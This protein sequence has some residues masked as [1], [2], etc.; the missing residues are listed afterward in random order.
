MAAPATK[1]LKM[2]FMSPKSKMIPEKQFDPPAPPPVVKI[3]HLSNEL[4]A[5]IV[6]FLQDDVRTLKSCSLTSH[7][8][9]SFSRRK[10]FNTVHLNLRNC[11][12]FTK[13]LETSPG[14]GPAVREL[15]VTV[16]AHE[17]PPWVDNRLF[18]ISEKLPNVAA[19][20]LKGKAIFTAA[21]ILGFRALRSIHFLGCELDS[22]RTFFT[23]IGSFPGMETMYAN[24]MVVYR[25]S[26]ALM[27][28]FSLP[29]DRRAKKFKSMSFNSCRMDADRFA[30]FFVESGYNKTLDYFATCPL[31]E[32]AL[33]AVG[34]ILKACGPRLKHYKFALVGMEEQG[35]YVEPLKRH[36]DLAQNTGLLTLELC[37]PAAYARLYGADDLSFAW[38]PALLA[39][40][41]SPYIEE[42]GFY[43]WEDDLPQLASPPWDDIVRLVG[44]PQFESLKRLAFHV[45]GAEP[46]AGKIA[47]AVRRKFAEFDARGV[48]LIDSKPDPAC[49]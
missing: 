47:A 25:E 44:Q 26:D 41:A 34:A 3:P 43:L 45:W 4:L 1:Y 36:Y 29:H 30:E 42:L 37:S 48:L 38:W 11:Q 49:V 27:E 10:L 21:P 24:E 5:R 28:Q 17:S 8:F 39:Q 2:S 13:I 6:D 15:H 9:L 22:T 19:L 16:S 40:V 18:S 23:L 46:A 7:R 12:K 14:V 32:T 35:G 20:Y 33:P 31:Q